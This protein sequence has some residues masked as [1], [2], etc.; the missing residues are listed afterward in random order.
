[1]SRRLER[2][3]VLGVV[4]G[5]GI[6]LWEVPAG[7]K[8]EL[9]NVSTYALADSDTFTAVT[10]EPAGGGFTFVGA[11][12]LGG[13]GTLIHLISLQGMPYYEGDIATLYLAS[14][15]GDGNVVASYVDV[16]F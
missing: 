4:N 15:L 3:T 8:Y 11:S 16:V 6:Q 9:L 14:A 7:H 1:V 5:F 10:L 12:E 2:T 13:I